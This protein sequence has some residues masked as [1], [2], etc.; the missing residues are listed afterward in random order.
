[1]IGE[2]AHAVTD[3]PGRAVLHMLRKERVVFDLRG[4]VAVFGIFLLAALQ[5]VSVDE[6][7][8]LLGVALAATLA[9]YVP[10][11]EWFQ[12]TDTMLYSLP[13]D[14]E[15]VVVAR[16]LVVVI[17]GTLAGVVWNGAGRILLPILAAGRED[18]AIW[19]TLEGGLTFALAV[20]LMA[21]LFFPLYFSFGMGRGAIAFLGMSVVILALAYVTSDL[22]WGPATEHTAPGTHLAVVL[23][24]ALIRSRVSALLSGLGV[25]GTLTVVLVVLALVFYAS[26]R[27]SQYGLRRREI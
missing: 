5:V 26:I 8:L 7:Y 18:P 24:S 17:T 20:G 9:V 15:T 16:Y 23:P 3:S 6:V 12:E 27:I 21:A 13:V 1:M 14:R 4:R 2:R 10:A 22:A 19:M 25:A 11:V